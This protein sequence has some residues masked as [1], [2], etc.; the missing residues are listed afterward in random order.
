MKGKR[1]I[2]M[3][4]TLISLVAT[5]AIFAFSGKQKNVAYANAANEEIQGFS[6]ELEGG[7]IFSAERVYFAVDED[8]QTNSEIRQ[9]P[10]SYNGYDFNA[11]ETNKGTEYFMDYKLYQPEDPQDYS[12]KDVIKNGQFVMVDDKAKD[13]ALLKDGSSQ[14]I[15]QGIMITFGGYYYYDNDNS[16]I[17]TNKSIVWIDENLNNK[18]DSGEEKYEWKDFNY[19]KIVDNG[20]LIDNDGEIVTDWEG[21][22]PLAEKIKVLDMGENIEFVTVQATLNTTDLSGP[23]VD[24]SIKIPGVRTYNNRNNDFTWFIDPSQMTE[25]HYVITISYMINKLTQIPYT[26]DFYLLLKSAY[27]Q[28]INVNNEEYTSKPTMVGFSG[29][30]ATSNASYLQYYYLND[31]TT[32][33]PSITFDYTRY[34]LSYTHI[35]G[36]LQKEINLKYDKDLLTLTT[37]VYGDKKVAEYPVDTLKITNTIVTIMFVDSGKYQFNFD[38]IYN[39][40][41]KEGLKQDTIPETDVDFP[42]ISLDIHGYQLKY[43]KSGFMSADM[44]YLEIYQNGT[45][46][47][48][49]NG[50]TDESKQTEGDT[51]GVKYK[52][53][54]TSDYKTGEILTAPQTSIA[55]SKIRNSD[56]SS[57]DELIEA[58]WNGSEYITAGSALEELINSF[59]YPKTDRGLWFTLT[60]TYNLDNSFYYYSGNQMDAKDIVAENED[61]TFKYRNNI[62]KITTFTNP[63]YY[64]IQIGYEYELDGN[65][66]STKQYFSFQI[67]SATPILELYKTTAENYDTGI[68]KTKFYDHEYTNQNVFANWAD[69]GVFE[70]K[71]VGKLYYST[72]KYPSEGDLRAAADGFRV[73]DVTSKTYSKNEMLRGNGSYMLVLEV[74]HSS[75]RTY[76]YFTIDKEK[77]SGLQI[78]E[79]ITNSID[80]KAVYSIKRDSSLNYVTHT[81]KGVIDSNFT[82][83]WNNKASG[84]GI[85]ATYKFTP[86][87][88]LNES[89]NGSNKLVEQVGPNT[90]KYILNEYTNGSSSKEIRIEKPLMLSATLNVDNVLT[91]Q[92]I[93]EF[94]LIDEAGNTLSYIVVVDRTEGVI[95]ATYGEEKNPY[96][97]GEKVTDYVELEWG[98]HKAIKLNDIN[99]ESTIGRLLSGNIASDYYDEI[100]NNLY[101]LSRLFTIVNGTDHV[102]AIENSYAEI[103]I[104]DKDL[105][106]SY[107]LY[108]NGTKEIRRSNSSVRGWDELANR[109]F[110]T[111]NKGSTADDEMFVDADIR[112]NLDSK[113]R[114]YTIGI[115]GDGQVTNNANTKFQVAITPDKAQG[116]V[117]SSNQKESSVYSTQVK[118]A[119]E[120]TKYIDNIQDDSHINIE[121]YYNGQASNDGVFVFE[122][123]IPS[124]QDNFK[125]TEV[126]Y[127]HFEL[128]DQSA[129]NSL[130][131]SAEDIRNQYMYYPYKYL[132]TEYILKTEGNIETYRQYTTETRGDKNVYRSSIINIGYETYYDA[133]GDLVTQQ[134]TQSGLYIITR[135]LAI[136]SD[137]TEPEQT[138]EFSYAFFVD[139]NKIISYPILNMEEKLVGQFIHASIPNSTGEIHYDKF[140]TQGLT[141]E[142]N[143]YISSDGKTEKTVQYKVYLETNKLPTQIKVPTG[144]YVTGNYNAVDNESIVATSYTNLNLKLSVYFLDTY[145]LLSLSKQGN[146]SVFIKIMD[147]LS[148]NSDGYINLS[149]SSDDVG[150]LAEFRN[151]RIHNE[152]NSLSLPGTYIFEISDTVG[153]TLDDDWQ[154]TDNYKFVFGVK[155]TNKAPLI[156]IY[157]Y[158]QTDTGEVVNKQQ[159]Q[160]QTTYTN[161][162]FIE[163]E[164]PEEDANAIGAQLD[165]N[166]VEIWRA[167]NEYSASELWLK[168]KPNPSGDGFMADAGGIVGNVSPVV[169]KNGKYII[170]LDSGAG[171]VDENGQ[172]VGY[173]EYVYYIHVRYILKNSGEKYYTYR[174]NGV[175][176][177]FYKSI[178]VVHIDR[179]PN[180]TNLNHLMEDQGDYFTKYHEWLSK[181]SVGN[182]NKQFAYSNPAGADYYGLSN[183]LYYR[184]VEENNYDMATKSMYAIGVNSNTLFDISK[185][186]IVYYR[187]LEFDSE[188]EAKTRMGLLPISGTYFGNSAGFQTFRED[189]LAYTAYSGKNV[190]SGNANLTYWTILTKEKEG[191]D[192]TGR[193][194]EIIEKDFAGNYTQYVIYCAPTTPVPVTIELD[195]NVL[196]GN[197][198]DN[199]IL[200]FNNM[201]QVTFM[202]IS[203]VKLLDNIANE[204]SSYYYP[205]YASISIYNSSNNTIKKTLYINSKTLHAEYL[206]DGVYSKNGIESEIFNEIKEQGNYIIEYVDTYGRTYRVKI[207]NYTSDKHSLNLSTLQVKTDY[208]TGEKYLSFR[209]VNTKIDD[210]TYW[211]VTR[212]EVK[213]NKNGTDLSVAF[214]AN[215]DNGKTS[216][217]LDP[218]SVA[219]PE[220][221]VDEI[222]RDR[223]NLAGGI[224][225]LI[226]LTDV[227]GKIVVVPVS[228]SEGY[229]AYQLF[230]QD[231]I[232]QRD[233]VI[234][235]ASEVKISYNTDFYEVDVKVYIDNKNSAETE[236]INYYT[237]A[238]EGK[239]TELKL[240]PDINI[241]ADYYGSL[242]KFEVVLLLAGEQSQSYEIWIDTRTTIFGIENT[243]KEDKIKYVK[244]TLNNSESDYSVVDLIDN[245][246]Y[247]DLITETV[248][249]TWSRN[250]NNYF[251]YSY[252]LYEF[253]SKDTYNHLIKNTTANTYTLSPKESNTGKYI[254]KVTIKSNDNVWIASRVFAVYMSTTITGL[255]EV[256]DG[257]GN[258]HNY[259]SITN[260]NEIIESIGGNSAQMAT[261]LGFKDADAM[262]RI[263]NNF[264]YTTAVPVYI[265]N[266]ELKLHSNQDN[267]VQNA[268]YEV[269]L[270]YTTIDFYR[271]YRSNYQTFAVIINIYSNNENTTDILSVFSFK[272]SSSN[273]IDLL[274]S[275]ISQVVYDDNA[276]YYKLEFDSYNKNTNSNAL[277][278]HNKIIIDIYYNDNFAKRVKGGND[279]KT[280]IEF[281]DAGSYRLEIKDV[282]GNK[283]YFGSTTS[284]NK[285]TIFRLFVMKEILYTINNEAPIQYAYYTYD[286]D[287]EEFSTPVTLEI[288]RANDATGRNNY[289]INSINVS[290]LLNGKDYKGYTH[291]VESSI[292]VFRDYGTYLITITAKLL[293]TE[294]YVTSQLVFTILN[295]N[296]ARSALDFTS[297]YGYNI[298]S[299]FNIRTTGGVEVSKDVTDA[300]MDLL[301]D[302][303]N[304]EGVNV[305]NKLITYDR[306][307]EKLGTSTQ[308]KMKFK[309]KYEV[310]SDLLPSREVEFAFTLNNEKASIEASIAPGG[311]TTKTVILKFNPASIYDQIG[312]CYLVINGEKVLHIKEGAV[313]TI[314]EVEV[315]DVGKYYVQLVGDSGNIATSFNFTIKEPLN[316]IAIILIVIIVAIVVSLIGT[317]IWLRTRMKVR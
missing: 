94:N 172:I 255:Y 140:N 180:Q 97:S 31:T 315:K 287:D 267:G 207:N 229:Y 112:I 56:A 313:N 127:S 84:A 21:G 118:V 109:L 213:Y 32:Q 116:N 132:K 43:S 107:I 225:Y 93:Y 38:Y 211:F 316:M 235:T 177:S 1:L 214:L 270:S 299:V 80:N 266:D 282:A 283:Q 250:E 6:A 298:I 186:S 60:D 47:I 63:G 81:L 151:A 198:F 273:S 261:A 27:E 296:E 279:D 49:A 44:K 301:Q 203:G 110:A 19:D 233:N 218:D 37:E 100:G 247:T 50:F 171:T 54:E 82:L 317:F 185:L 126:R 92:G 224:Q 170:K 212:V 290:V 245:D 86:F 141:D 181:E 193:Y 165:I 51:L 142:S 178:Y 75:T 108:T 231:N 57:I 102:F 240:L 312:D 68:V 286:E 15:K 35:S 176:H 216:F 195:G 65:I 262:K 238:T 111:D 205:Y 293:N 133:N 194:Y 280:Y 274:R 40:E 164:I 26:F 87:V 217:I 234:Y 150:I 135:T 307:I 159:T 173:K 73:V 254:L 12:H 265:S 13:V 148:V 303:S 253:T 18:V 241:E 114:Y 34:K 220:V 76:T 7:A 278:K 70:S 201:D 314:T 258:A 191:F 257:E 309:V 260:I 302:K 137:G 23:K 48:L 124:E 2:L 33:Y 25:G 144:K 189:L 153:K 52:L 297:I 294:H 39:Y 276:E 281:K 117:Y 131:G 275:G 10:L 20:E 103:K 66:I 120:D 263:F 251:K 88:K 147:N 29:E 8:G 67:T 83:G 59:T 259:S 239:Y 78:Y 183:E 304:T 291:P 113:T 163:F 196:S 226:I 138:S 156:D 3:L 199:K 129:L 45:M 104:S 269:K 136:K 252:D 264:G 188:S 125:V 277:E 200:T 123:L 232:Y 285:N 130:D 246:F 300:F 160:D 122:W 28:N 9:K 22:F 30:K 192:P 237:T 5:G 308:G 230:T 244:S 11:I 179:S 169:L 271:V 284:D 248:N 90:Y 228:T 289:D 184:Y 204:N 101:N 154:T 17:K 105:P 149:F 310:A 242:R 53:I 210:Y 4:F 162:E 190:N 206:G 311:K 74:E 187:T 139:R 182:T 62:T 36:D 16:V 161:Q 222:D 158:A 175:N 209:D 58:C 99:A 24:E 98:T 268:C 46:F 306:I 243:N 167:N 157:H 272:T 227:A 155:L 91:D 236:N 89:R 121:G 174:D 146:T 55:A 249:I 197:N 202:G 106:Q 221:K 79:V 288:K 128:M 14:T 64:I 71:V 61:R 256:K 168:L 292:Y 72:G 134:V 295:P 305:Y 95:N 96:K 143:I 208:S 42:N 77:I 152:D 223:L 145:K 69:T 215:F 166:T 41:D 219:R 115:I 119:D 85:K